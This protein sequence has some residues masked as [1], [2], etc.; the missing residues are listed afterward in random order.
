M[1]RYRTGRAFPGNLSFPAGGNRSL[2][3]EFRSGETWCFTCE[4]KSYKLTEP[5]RLVPEC[6]HYLL[7]LNYPRPL[8]RFAI[9]ID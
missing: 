4:I 2:A 7:R 5:R 8:T 9:H 1:A 6:V 3:K